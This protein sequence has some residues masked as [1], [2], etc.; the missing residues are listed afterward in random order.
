M[1]RT[2]KFWLGIATIIL[3][4]GAILTTTWAYSARQLQIVR[5]QPVYATPE[6]GTRELIACSYSG[7]NK[8][9][10]VHAGREIFDDLW[11]VEAHVWAA[12][13]SDG[14]GFSGQ[15]YDKPGWFFLRVQNGW[16]FMPEDKFPEIIAFGKWFF[17]LSG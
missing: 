16:V 13:R 5:G 2:R 17:G 1:N 3:L 11:F 10:I 14:K 4:A 7:V 9:E 8:V 6:K 15:D 12:S